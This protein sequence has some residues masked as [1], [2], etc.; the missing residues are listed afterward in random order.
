VIQLCDV[1]IR[2]VVLQHLAEF[3]MGSRQTVSCY[4]L[5]MQSFYVIETRAA[6]LGKVQIGS[7]VCRAKQLQNCPRIQVVKVW[8]VQ[9]AGQ[10]L[11]A[12]KLHLLEIIIEI[13]RQSRKRANEYS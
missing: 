2:P 9:N 5:Y 8:N 4:D 7:V 11:T 1:S 6:F 10:C 13:I 3:A 12:E